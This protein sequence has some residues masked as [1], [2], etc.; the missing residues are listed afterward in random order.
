MELSPLSLVQVAPASSEWKTPP[1][2]GFDQRPDAVRIGG[3]DGHADAAEDALGHAGIVGD[4]LPCVAAVGRLP[5][6]AVGAAALEGPR[7]AHHLPDA[8]VE[9]ARIQRIHGQV[10]APAFVALEEDFLPGLAAVLGAEDAALG[11]GAGHVAHGG[12]VDEVGIFGVDANLR[13]SAAYLRGRRASRSCRRR[14]TCRRRRRGR[15]CR[16]WSLSPMPT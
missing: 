5:E 6:A 3:R 4:F 12:D 13:R 1:S 8:G 9:D 15:R 2:C 7:L 14:W 16:E 10:D 11:V